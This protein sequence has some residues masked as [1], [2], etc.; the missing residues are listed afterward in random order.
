MRYLFFL[1]TALTCA[2]P[3]SAQPGYK[4]QKLGFTIGLSSHPSMA[5]IN[6]RRFG[7]DRDT[8]K[9]FPVPVN[10]IAGVEYTI[11]RKSVIG[12]DVAYG[13]NFV[14]YR[15]PETFDGSAGG[16]YYIEVDPYHLPDSLKVP[17]NSIMILDR[18][19]YVSTFYAGISWKLFLGE[20]L[21]PMGNFV[22]FKFGVLNVSFK[23]GE[24]YTYQTRSA[25]LGPGITNS[26]VTKDH[27]VKGPDKLKPLPY[28][29]CSYHSRK[30]LSKKYKL[31]SDVG[32]GF[33]YLLKNGIPSEADRNLGSFGVRSVDEIITG[34]TFSYVAK[35]NFLNLDFKLLYLL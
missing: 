18:N 10:P 3:V 30:Q 28:I 23:E 21:A 9:G 17:S 35:Q 32:F 34:T 14:G 7:I 24:E 2:F 22:E 6:S 5:I 13:R 11:S 33:A 8:P 20:F 16:R 4:S 27:V 31:F 19:R 1:I 26:V 29:G 12:L 25:I 15:L